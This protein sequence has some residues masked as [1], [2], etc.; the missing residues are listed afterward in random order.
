[1]KLN[2]ILNSIIG[3][4]AFG[5]T[6]VFASETTPLDKAS[7]TLA[8]AIPDT[9][10]KVEF[11]SNVNDVPVNFNKDLGLETDNLVASIGATWRPWENHQFSIAYFKNSAQNT[12]V[13]DDPIEWDGVEYDG[14]V[15]ANTS[16]NNFDFS[17]I[18]WVANKEKWALG[19]RLGL[20]FINLDFGIDLLLDAN[21][22]PVTDDSFDRSEKTNL[23][24]PS[25]GIAWRWVPAQSWRINMDAGYLT[26]TV[27]DFDGSILYL[28]GGVE[29][30]PWENWGFS[31]NAIRNSLDVSSDQADFRGNLDIT[32]T[33]YNF[34]VTYRF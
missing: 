14:T 7:F 21:G 32:Q 16:T 28:A 23:P 11:E 13:L 1:M 26:A 19:P 6:S 15:K 12:L 34:G 4:A 30:F 20:T 3:I 33:N 2:F 17:Y 25:L 10:T 22:D 29:W 8:L 9:S 31:L 18:W 5:S 27:G 24:A